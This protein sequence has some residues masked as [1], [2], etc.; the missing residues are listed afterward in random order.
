MVKRKSKIQKVEGLCAERKKVK[1]EWE[2]EL[3][4]AINT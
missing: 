3:V 1:K 4:K 2:K